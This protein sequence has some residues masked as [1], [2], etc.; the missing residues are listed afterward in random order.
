MEQGEILLLLAVHVVLTGLPGVAATLFAARLGVRRVP[1][2]LGIGLAATGVGAMLAFWSYYASPE[3]GEAFSYLLLFG[4][5][6]LTVWSLYGGRIEP[7]LLRQLATPLALWILGS[8]FLVFLGFVHGGADSSIVTS[9]TRFSAGPLP[10]D[11]DIPHF[12]TEW[13][14]VHGHHGTPPLY[15]PDWRFS[16]RPPLQVGYMLSQ[17][18]ILWDS[19]LLDYQL[20]GVLLQQLWIVAV[21]ALLLAARVGRVTRALVIG[22]VLLSDVALVN[23]FF[24][25]PKM[26]PAAMLLAAAALVATPLWLELRRNLWAAALVA[27]LLGLAM[28][29]HG[30]SVFGAIPIA[31]IAVWRGL[32]SWRWV[33]VAALTGIVL[34]APWS[35]YQKYGDPPGDRLT[36]WML[37]GVDEIDSRT[38][39]EAIFDSYGEAGF[40]GTLHNKAENF[41]TMAGGGPFGHYLDRAGD[42]IGEGDWSAAVKE[43]RSILFL[44][45]IPSLGLLLIAPLLMLFGRK[46]G[47]A[48]PDGDWSFALTCLLI[49][50]VG[51]VCWGLLLFGDLPSR[52]VLHAGSFALPVLAFCGFVAGLRATF[53]RF[54]NWYVPI[55]ALLMFALYVPAFGSE[56]GSSYSAIGALLALVSLVGFGLF[57]WG[58]DEAAEP[59]LA[60]PAP[61]GVTTGAGAGASPSAAVP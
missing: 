37:A 29:G 7:A 58:S 4:S 54:A 33:G 40:G 27:A 36:K 5:V 41:V 39:R 60:E 61:S 43:V 16:D 47:R 18:G 21:W 9:A 42:A 48:S 24:V 11:N 55:S 50:A 17:R 31:L 13:F 35:A 32:P 20:I 38:T 12:Y 8:A 14:F 28:L 2:L 52:T 51:A 19:K 23:G 1:V 46:R 26:L 22:T 6:M 10:S 15:P 30:S 34:M 57:A 25:W 53:P 44:Y 3:V 45:F 56:P 49:A 59:A